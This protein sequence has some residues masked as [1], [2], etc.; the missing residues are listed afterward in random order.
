MSGVFLD[1][2]PPDLRAIAL[3]RAERLCRAVSSTPMG[4][5][6]PEIGHPFGLRGTHASDMTAV[7]CSRQTIYSLTVDDTP[8]GMPPHTVDGCTVMVP[9]RIPGT[10]GEAAR[11][12]AERLRA[13]LAD[14]YV[15][16]FDD[17]PW[18]GF[19]GALAAALGDRADLAILKLRSP[20]SVPSVTRIP[21]DGVQGGALIED[22]A[23]RR[24]IEAMTPTWCGV[25]VLKTFDS[26]RISINPLSVPLGVPD[27]DPMAT[28]RELGTWPDH[29]RRI[30]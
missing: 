21:V 14:P 19:A 4:E 11:D 17:R 28:L 30:A 16:S 3:E 20:W 22:E 27:R 1:R 8:Q 12:V 10:D 29:L 2:V 13:A 25:S 18:E 15:P 26:I 7:T 24:E 5:W 23:I 6:R 9:L